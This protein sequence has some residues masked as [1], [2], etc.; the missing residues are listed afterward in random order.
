MARMSTGRRFA[1]GPFVLDVD[2]HALSRDGSPVTVGSRALGVLEALVAHD[3]R[4]V[5]KSALID[6]AWP[7]MVVEESNLSVQIAALRKV[8]GAAPDGEWIATVA[9]IGY[10]FAAP[11][12]P[13]ADS[14]SAVPGDATAPATPSIAVLPFVDLGGD[15]AHESFA[16]GLT[17]DLI[18]ALSRYRW[19]V[20]TG[21]HASFAYK[22]RTIGA[23]EVGRALGVRYVLEGSVRG[24][25]ERVRISA[26]LVDAETDTQLWSER[27]DVERGDALA[28]QD[29]ITERVAGALEPELLKSASRH[30]VRRPS[31]DASAWDLVHQGTW[32]FHQVIREGHLRARDLFRAA[33]LRDP[34]LAEA[35]AWLA[36]VSAGIVAYGWCD[37]DGAVLREGLDA[38]ATAV[39][40][41]EANP[42]S[43]YALAIVSVMAGAFDQAIR[44]AG[45]S[46]ES[47][48]SFALGHLVLG[49][50]RLYR[51]D[52][53]GAVAP[54]RQG[55]TLNA[56]DPQN[57]VWWNLLGYAELFSGGVDAAL[58][59]A[60]AALN[61]RPRWRAALEAAACCCVALGR[62]DEAREY[63]RQL[64]TLDA[65]SG[66]GLAPMK[67]ANPE[68][69]AQIDALLREAAAPA[70]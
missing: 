60:C 3:G 59:S 70:A 65:A 52:A 50:A 14:P 66:D 38:A 56:H 39:E 32:H 45:K 53:G 5:T 10:R 26:R 51:G 2:R 19:F 57:F 33:C 34:R 8:L 63:A 68:W 48:P 44:A 28:A 25:G 18:T 61:A 24:S 31:G 62:R 43:H 54:L 6:A 49:M 9:R 16:D 15:A 20:V 47:S 27:H 69:V 21:R 29:A 11:I 23:R 41:D 36:R 30:A 22:G 37:D 64:G 35:H 67:R 42:Y 4:T 17:E 13:L 12:T 55:L 7:G 1:F 58:Q 46:I 40:L